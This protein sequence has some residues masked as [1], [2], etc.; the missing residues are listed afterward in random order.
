VTIGQE[1]SEEKGLNTISISQWPSASQMKGGHNKTRKAD[2]SAKKICSQYS[3]RI[4]EF[5]FKIWWRFIFK[6]FKTKTLMDQSSQTWDWPPSV[7]NLR[8]LW[9]YVL[10]GFSGGGYN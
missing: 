7:L 1:T 10:S 8:R 4:W 9:T 6:E 5:M 3:V 2:H